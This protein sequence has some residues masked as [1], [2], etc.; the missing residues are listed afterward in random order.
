MSATYAFL[1]TFHHQVR[2]VYGI[3]WDTTAR[4]PGTDVEGRCQCRD[5][6]GAM[7]LHHGDGFLIEQGAMLHRVQAS[8]DGSFYAFRTVTMPGDATTQLVRLGN[9]CLQLVRRPL[10]DAYV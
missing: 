2:F 3:L 8:T 1:V 7:L 4:A 6:I 9:R 5:V 10:Q